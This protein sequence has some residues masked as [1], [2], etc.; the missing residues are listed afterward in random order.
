MM[1]GSSKQKRNSAAIDWLRACFP[2]AL[3]IKLTFQLLHIYM[4]HSEISFRTNF[5]QYKSLLKQSCYSVIYLDCVA[6]FYFLGIWISVQKWKNSFC[7][8][9]A[10]YIAM[11]IYSL[12]RLLLVDLRVM[13]ANATCFI[14]TFFHN[15][16]QAKYF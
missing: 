2:Y 12:C 5:A 6:I 16:S 14:T 9:N 10:I 13:D 4:D 11:N 1:N 7:S 3:S 8:S 15:N